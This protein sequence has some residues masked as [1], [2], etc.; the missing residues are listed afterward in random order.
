MITP[1]CII[2]AA[3]IIVLAMRMLEV[4]SDSDDREEEN[5]KDEWDKFFGH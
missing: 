5:E 4:A 2:I 3:C 1:F